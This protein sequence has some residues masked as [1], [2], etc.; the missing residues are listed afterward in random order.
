MVSLDH[1]AF[2]IMHSSGT[3]IALAFDAAAG[4][5]LPAVKVL[6]FT[7]DILSI[8]LSQRAIVSLDTAL[9]GLM[10]LMNNLMSLS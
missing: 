1:P 2:A 8:V 3:A 10:K 9:C 7:P 4:L 6:V 5:T